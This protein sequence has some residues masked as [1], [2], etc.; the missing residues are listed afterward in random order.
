MVNRSFDNLK[1]TINKQIKNII[2]SLVQ[3]SVLYILDIGITT[4]TNNN[5]YY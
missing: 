3:N 2:L 4:T 1:I 5:Y